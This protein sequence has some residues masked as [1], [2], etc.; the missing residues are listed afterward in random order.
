MGLLKRLLGSK[1]P[2]RLASTFEIRQVRGV[3]VPFQAGAVYPT[4]EAARP[5][6]YLLDNWFARRVERPVVSGPLPRTE[7]VRRDLAAEAGGA[8]WP[9]ASYVPCQAPQGEAG[10][11]WYARRFDAPLGYRGTTTRLVFFAANHLSDVF[12]NGEYLGWHEGGYT[13]FSFLVPGERLA[14]RDND[15]RVR[16]ERP[17]EASDLPAG[18]LG[19]VYFEA[20]PAARIER[21]DAI[22][23]GD[24]F[25]CTVV[26][27]GAIPRGSLIRLGLHTAEASDDLSAE[28]IRGPEV[29]TRDTGLT[30]MDGVGVATDRVA[31]PD[32]AY[33]SPARP[34]LYVVRA[35]LLCDGR[36]LD[37]VSVQ[38]GLRTVGLKDGRLMLTGQPSL[39]CG[40]VRSRQLGVDLREVLAQGADLLLGPALDLAMPLM[41]D[42]LGLALA[43]PV[44]TLQGAETMLQPLREMVF[45]HRNRPSVLSL[46]VSEGEAAGAATGR[47]LEELNALGSGWT[48]I[49]RQ[50]HGLTSGEAAKGNVILWTSAMDA[51]TASGSVQLLLTLTAEGLPDLEAYL[52]KGKALCGVVADGGVGPEVF[53]GVRAAFRQGLWS[54]SV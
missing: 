2:D 42:R 1:T 12:L 29:A 6:L 20:L 39:L 52:R 26:A 50:C 10:V 33:W 5:R 9:P 24:G 19:P 25:S 35:D 21:L 16:V 45:L 4:F 41:A 53:E 36:L 30:V 23:D 22:P 46:V 43:L 51:L 49:A 8:T 48:L 3:P 13:P 18:I 7:A 40:L 15:L 47:M 44:G 38:A 37:T 54:G 28:A 14:D 11:V 34:T 31:P 17:E 32:A 27:A